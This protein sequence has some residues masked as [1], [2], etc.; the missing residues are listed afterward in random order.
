MGKP[1]RTNA[2]VMK[3]IRDYIKNY[4]KVILVSVVAMLICYG[5]LVF[6]GNIR[7][8][9]E[10]LINEPGSK[11]GWLTIGR[12]SLALFKDLLGLGTHS[13]IKSGFFF[14]LFFALGTILL[15]AA[16]YHFSGKKAY[17]Y[18]VFMLLY[19][20]SNIWSFQIYFSVQ[21]AEVACAMFLLVIAAILMFE[22]F[23]EKNGLTCVWRIVIAVPVVALGLGA[24]QALAAYYIAV[25]VMLFLAY[26]DNEQVLRNDDE[27]ERKRINRKLVG[28]VAGLI[29]TFG[30][31]YVSYNFVA[32]KWFMTTA[33][34]MEGQ[35]GWG[36]Y[37]FVDCV[38]NVLRTVKNVLIGIGPRNFSFYTIGVLLSLLLIVL[39]MRSKSGVHKDFAFWLRILA[40][41]AFMATPFLMTIYM[42]EMLVTRSQFALPVVAA[43][44]GMYTLD[45]ISN[46]MLRRAERCDGVS[47]ACQVR[48]I[49]LAVCRVCVVLVI[50]GQVVYNF[51]LAATDEKRYAND[52][53]MTEE[54]VEM[55]LEANEGEFPSQPIV[56]VG[57]Q[58]PELDEWC[59]RTEM[60]GWSFYGWDY[61]PENP[62]GP[63]HRIAGFV[64]VHTGYVVNEGV[65][66]EDKEL[67]I[68]VAGGL[69][70]FPSENSFVIMDELVV[71]R[72]S[73]VSEGETLDWW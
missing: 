47:R 58:E 44:L 25:C 46:Y 36:K 22:A 15:A 38:K 56:F 34:Y 72:L 14:F 27:Q 50:V 52:V 26:M 40:L 17:P 33:G 11:L 71:V 20:T 10:E 2:S 65:S 8:D 48:K 16:I 60:Y 70:D 57:Y 64:Q 13:V 45:G 18:W 51:R 3:D 12:F 63:T 53:A 9:T 67:A 66:E 39:W 29:A 30:I 31:A 43:F 42:G 24:Y 32:N 37:A 54:L 28:G 5:F 61:S 21:Q 35:M 6:S 19:M 1:K 7:I 68:E 49:V 73:A 41:V 55:L 4:R 69:N 62:T 59:R 23:F